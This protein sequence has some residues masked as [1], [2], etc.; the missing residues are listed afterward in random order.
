MLKSSYPHF[1]PHYQQSYSHISRHKVVIHT[2]W[3]TSFFIHIF[4][5]KLSTL[6]IFFNSAFDVFFHIIHITTT[7]TTNSIYLIK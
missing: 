2:L 1:Y 7:I 5:N 3:I 4:F 6:E